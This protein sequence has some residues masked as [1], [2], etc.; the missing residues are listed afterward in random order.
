MLIVVGANPNSR[1]LQGATPFYVAVQEGQME[2][3]QLR[4]EANLLLA[5]THR[6]SALPFLP[7]DIAALPTRRALGGGSGA[8]TASRDRRV[9]R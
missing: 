4:A 3:I 1:S 2:E 7:L 6:E 9:W 5:G 8:G